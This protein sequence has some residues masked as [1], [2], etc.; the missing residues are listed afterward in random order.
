[1]KR[2]TPGESGLEP[3]TWWDYKIDSDWIYYLRVLSP[4]KQEKSGM[5]GYSKK[6]FFSE[7]EIFAY[8]PKTHVAYYHFIGID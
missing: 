5:N 1:M 3:L 7:T 2:E 4:F 8:N 6:G